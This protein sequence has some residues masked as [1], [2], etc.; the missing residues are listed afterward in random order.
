MSEKAR[1]LME[2]LKQNSL[3]NGKDDP[4]SV[5]FYIDILNKRLY[6]QRVLI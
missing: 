3:E 5:S 1:V 2:K 4:D 6:V